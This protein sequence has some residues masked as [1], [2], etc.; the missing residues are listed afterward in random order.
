MASASTLVA[1]LDGLSSI[2]LQ[3]A[4]YKESNKFGSFMAL[5]SSL[6]KILMELHRGLLYLIEHEAHSKLLTLLFKILRLLILSTPAN[7]VS[8]L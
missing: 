3:V 2:F 7:M 8:W 6:G 1:M 4:E 5:S